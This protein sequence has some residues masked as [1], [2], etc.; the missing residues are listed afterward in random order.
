MFSK[1]QPTAWC[2]MH[3][4]G[5]CDFLSFGVRS[6]IAVCAICAVCATS[7]QLMGRFVTSAANGMESQYFRVPIK[8]SARKKAF[9]RCV[10]GKAE[11]EYVY[12]R[13]F[14]TSV[15]AF[16]CG[17]IASERHL[18]PLHR[19]HHWRWTTTESCVIENVS[20]QWSIHPFPVRSRVDVCLAMVL[21]SI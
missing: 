2:I 15:W 1:F 11:E 18:A 14:H 17:N 10:A 8:N 12:R 19:N 3:G 20:R 21:D 13:L 9:V 16:D 4:F 6:K 7:N 5:D